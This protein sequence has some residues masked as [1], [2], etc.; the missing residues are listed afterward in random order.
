MRANHSVGHR[1][2]AA[3]AAAA[4]GCGRT[5]GLALLAIGL[6]VG[7]A[8][9][10]D[11]GTVTVQA[12]LQQ[13]PATESKVLAVIPKGSAIKVGD[14]SNGWCHA[15]WNGRDGYILTKSMRLAGQSEAQ[16]GADDN[17]PAAPDEATATPSSPN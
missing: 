15:W 6:F 11:S 4:R 3:A 5:A 14:C 1:F 13:A 7:V 2:G 17:N 10:S 8:G 12:N 16:D 9:C